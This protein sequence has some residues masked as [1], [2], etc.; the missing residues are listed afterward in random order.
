MECLE[1]RLPEPD[2]KKTET[3]KIV[4]KDAL[5]GPGQH[6]LGGGLVDTLRDGVD[7]G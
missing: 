1:D 5:Y 4:V 6:D 3:S 7:H 2:V